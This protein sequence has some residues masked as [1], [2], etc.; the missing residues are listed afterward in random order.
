MKK[1]AVAAIAAASLVA[2]MPAD[3]MSIAPSP[4]KLLALAIVWF[5]TLIAL[6]GSVGLLLEA[7]LSQ[8]LEDPEA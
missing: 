1:F 5:I 6:A 4:T 7:I 2:A 8:F 3:A